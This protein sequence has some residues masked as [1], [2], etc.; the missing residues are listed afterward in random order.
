M[1]GATG[2][3]SPPSVR[4]PG[5]FPRDRSHTFAGALQASVMSLHGDRTRPNPDLP[6]GIPVGIKLLHTPGRSVAVRLLALMALPALLAAVYLLAIRP[7]Q[8]HWGATSE[9]AARSM[10]GD[11]LVSSPSFCATRGVTIHGRPEDVWPW[12]AQ[13]G[14]GRAGFYGYDLIENVGSRT[15]IRSAVSI[16]PDLQHPKTGDV[17]PISA[18]AS[19][20]FDS[21]R[22]GSYLIWRGDPTPSNGSFLWALY[23]VDESHT[24]LISR[25]RLRYHWTDRRLLLDLFTEFADH[26][27]VP[28]ILLGIKGRVEGRPTQPLAGEA[29][30]I[31][32]WVLGLAELA[33]AAVLI[34]RWR[35]WW[36]AW[37]LGLAAGL[38]LLFALYAH[39]AMWIGA[40]LGCGI[41]GGMLLLSRTGSASASGV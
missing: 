14:Y 31:M 34:V 17:L 7:S 26:V 29:M 28:K 11:D 37:F 25:I 39:A 40:V 24:R 4:W 2:C 3:A 6:P 13:M 9:E 10:P 21:M 30:E 15:G 23:P 8:L 5:C 38:L 16:L 19:L 20:V 12:L 1:N 35:R 22:G 18:I 32:V 27:A 41:V 33:T 36:R